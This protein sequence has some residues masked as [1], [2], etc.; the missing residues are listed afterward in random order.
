MEGGFENGGLVVMEL[1]HGIS[2]GDHAEERKNHVMA[3]EE[4][5]GQGLGN[6]EFVLVV[7]RLV[8]FWKR[9]KKVSVWGMMAKN[10]G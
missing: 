1:D 6:G 5:G 7:W 8:L 10:V 4:R 3:L 2:S 9:S